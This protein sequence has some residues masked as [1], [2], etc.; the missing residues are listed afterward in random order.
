MRTR[1]NGTYLPIKDA[2]LEAGK[3]A[4]LI[5]DLISRL[6]HGKRCDSDAC[7]GTDPRHSPAHPP[8]RAALS[9]VYCK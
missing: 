5:R 9:E 8:H 3:G 6:R 4:I 2:S 1:V 7:G